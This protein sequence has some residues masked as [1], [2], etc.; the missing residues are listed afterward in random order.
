MNCPICDSPTGYNRTYCDKHAHAINQIRENWRPKILKAKADYERRIEYYATRIQ[1]ETASYISSEK[2][3]DGA[4][5]AIK[6]KD[7]ER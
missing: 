4:L 2:Y 1:R 7:V 5:A 3:P 6:L